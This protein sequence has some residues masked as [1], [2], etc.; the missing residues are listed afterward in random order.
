MAFI[1]VRMPPG[2]DGVET[3]RKIWEIDPDL[4]VVLCTAYSDYSWDEMFEKLGQHDGL[5]VLKKPFDAVEA[6]QLAHGLTEKWR[7][8]RASKRTVTELEKAVAERTVELASK[9]ALLKAQVDSSLD[10]ILV[11]DSQGKQILK[12]ERFNTL[13][14]IPRHLAEGADDSKTLEFVT[15]QTR[16]PKQF[17]EK[18]AYLYSRLEEISRDEI[19]LIDGTVLDRYSSPVRGENGERYGRI[20]T[21]R[22][23]TERKRS[24]EELKRSQSRLADAQRIARVGSWDWDLVT[25]KRSWSDQFFRL[26]GFEPGEIEPSYGRYLAC[27][28]P[29]DR[30]A[31]EQLL[32]DVLATQ[33]PASA[34]VRVVHP[35]GEVRI[36]QAQARVI[37]DDSGKV[38]R[39]VG[40]MQDVT[41]VRQKEREL[42]LAKSA[43]ETATHAKSEF[44]ASMSHEIRTP[45]NGVIGMTNLLLDSDLSGDQRHYAEAISKS[46]ES[47]LSVINDIL[48]FSKIEAGKL[49]FETVILICMKQSRVVWSCSPSVRRAKGWNLRA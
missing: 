14:K 36:L 21:F 5:F 26:L 28:H 12:N 23:I 49:T 24:E 16:N 47:L 31:A 3:V 48:D 11:V 42:L 13:W 15:N 33:K 37:V 41:E 10:G 19:D 43:A 1:D 32:E 18:V 29:D 30:K 44:L 27:V 39:R 6:L 34:D 8:F 4:Q 22:D 2:W 7:L 38:V 9:N 45:M 25:G 40:T 20:W 35:D 46:G 17:R